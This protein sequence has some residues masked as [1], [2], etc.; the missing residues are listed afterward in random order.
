MLKIGHRGAGGDVPENTIASFAEAIKSGANAVELDVRSTKDNKL[1]V[2]HNEKVDKLTSAKGYVSDFTLKEIK[3]FDLKG[4]RVPTLGEALDFIDSK[5]DKILIEIKEPGTEKSIIDEI[6]KRKLNE[7]SIVIS[8]HE[9]ALK[10]VRSID[11]HIEIGFIYAS[12]KDPIATAKSVGA[13]YLLPLYR[14]THSKD[15]ERAHE[16]GFKVIAWTINTKEEME[17]FKKKGVDGIATDYPGI[18]AKV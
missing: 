18:L 17:E 12:Y 11:K 5:V 4:E 10:K 6:S 7:R 1:V 13:S 3:A 2:F 15:I 9:E 8:F 14:F 16:N